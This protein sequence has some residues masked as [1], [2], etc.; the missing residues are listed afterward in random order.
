MVMRGAA[1]VRRRGQARQWQLR[2]LRAAARHHH[3]QQPE[4]T[5]RHCTLTIYTLLIVGI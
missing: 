4:D 3:H 1:A 5:A 2:H